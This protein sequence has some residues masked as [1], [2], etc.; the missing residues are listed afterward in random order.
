MRPYL[1]ENSVEGLATRQT[2]WKN[3]RLV[4]ECFMHL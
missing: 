4:E 2:E 1:R 3:L